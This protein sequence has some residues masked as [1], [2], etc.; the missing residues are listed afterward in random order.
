[1]AKWLGFAVGAALAA[2]FVG[3]AVAVAADVTVGGLVQTQFIA[4]QHKPSTFIERAIR[5]K[6]SSKMTEKISA[7]VTLEAAKE[8]NLLDAYVDFACCPKLTIRSGQF[9]MPFGLETQASRFD[10]EAIENSLIIGELWNNGYG[11]GYSRDIGVMAT[12]RHKVFEFKLAAVNGV[13][14][15]Y[16][17][18]NTFFPKWGKDNDG[19]MDIVGR[20]GVGVPMFAGL[21]V[22]RYQGSWPATETDTT[23]AVLRTLGMDRTATGF[24]MYL[25][26]G[27]VLFQMEYIRGEGLLGSQWKTAGDISDPISYGGWYVLVGFRVTPLIEPVFK[28]DKYDPNTDVDDDAYSDIC[29]GL[30]LNFEGKARLQTCYRIKREEADENTLLNKGENNQLIV[31]MA[32]KF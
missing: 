15:N 27:K 22:S 23:D 8:P 10:Q 18:S 20:F 28:F 1:M 14:Y 7:M 29:L 5:I 30:N 24:D 2:T 3:S 31:Q 13:G 17:E 21:G 32:G 6:A 12:A 9:Q 4:E 26:A 11:K 25:D 16:G 19:H